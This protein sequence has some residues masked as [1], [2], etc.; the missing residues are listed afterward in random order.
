M[1]KASIKTLIR[2]PFC[3]PNIKYLETLPLEIQV[4]EFISISVDSKCCKEYGLCGEPY[5]LDIFF[6]KVS[7]CS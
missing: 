5:K 2:Q 4:R 6:S 1:V 7:S 3:N